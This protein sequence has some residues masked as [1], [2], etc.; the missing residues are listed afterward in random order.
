MMKKRNR[1]YNRIISALLF[2]AIILTS[3]TVDVT[4]VRAD[5]KKLT[6]AAA[7]KLI[8]ENSDKIFALEGKVE[9]KEAAY[10]AAVTSVALK[11]KNLST[12]RWSPLL[13]FKFPSQPDLVEAY[14][15][16]YKPVQASSAIT[17]AKHALADRYYDEYKTVYQ[18]FVSIIATQ[19]KIDFNQQRLELMQETLK[20]NKARWLLGEASEEDIK[21]MEKT[22]ESLNKTIAS[23]G[24]VLLNAKKKL[25][26]SLGVD[27]TTGYDFEDPF[28]SAKIP[29]S[30]LKGLI[31]STLD[32]D[33]AYFNACSN[34]T[35]AYLSL[36]TNKELIKGHYKG[37]DYAIIDS[38]VNQALKGEKLNARGFKKAYESF[39]TAIDRYWQGHKWIIFFKIPRE[40]FRGSLDGV[41]YVEDDPYALYD[42]AL[43]YVDARN[44]QNAL[45]K[46]LTASVE[47]SFNN[48]A[49][50]KNV[51]DTNVQNVNDAKEE[52]K[53][54]AILNRVGKLTYDE[55]ASSQDSYDNLQ[56]DMLA[57][58]ADYSS[59]LYEF[60]RLTCGA[61]S[62]YMDG[63]GADVFAVGDGVSTIS[64]EEGKGANYYIS[65]IAQQNVF[66]LFVNIPDSVG[67]AVTD[68]ALIVNGTQIGEKTPV[69]EKLRHL[70]LD[71]SDVVS[72]KIRLYNG[73]NVVCDCQIDPQQYSGALDIVK[74]YKVD[75]GDK[76]EIGGYLLENDALTGLSK[77]TFNFDSGS[78]EAYFKLRTKDN[79]YIGGEDFNDLKK[80]FYY[81]G[82]L[83]ADMDTI[84][85]E[86][87][88]KDKNYL[89]DAI[90]SDI[91]NKVKKL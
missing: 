26:K 4:P 62:A 49:T 79:K 45:E 57:S 70:G 58:L 46:E 87:F 22:V 35:L 2:I 7:K 44:E 73:N 80:T 83:G 33:Q 82:V 69:T 67:V 66:D 43:A 8:I 71:F 38:Y 84:T 68:F 72:A 65:L 34:T 47:D 6:L 78:K 32:N 74:D 40:W 64:A 90:F 12:F 63:T 88:D 10:K 31:Q 20:K 76:K 59:A 23:D 24:V 29:V 77:L 21:N 60:D 41:R 56:Q 52:M 50:M 5:N 39:L 48:V 13:S 61:V 37:S 1:I 9:S 51:Y 17:V 53:K 11:K 30:A 27:V 86:L 15:F 19:Q 75:N 3:V 85:I 36:K 25:S 42:A 91:G 28:V 16:E 54:D 89:Y 55:F 81:V 14:E 18:S